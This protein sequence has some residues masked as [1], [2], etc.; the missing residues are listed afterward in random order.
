MPKVTEGTIKKIRELGMA[1]SLKEAQSGN[2]SDEFKE[3]VKRYYPNA[4][5]GP[6]TAKAAATAEGAASIKGDT[7]GKTTQEDDPGWDWRTMGNKK[8]GLGP[9]IMGAKAIQSAASR[10]AKGK[11]KS[12]VD[13]A[14][15][16]APTSGR[17]VNQ[18]KSVLSALPGFS[19]TKASSERRKK[20]EAARREAGRRR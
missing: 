6:N 2:A 12:I 9:A 17:G 16:K 10:R 11:G 18:S 4:K 8:R 14:A 15:I 3:A 1:R 20:V 13:T 7:K 5:F 19:A